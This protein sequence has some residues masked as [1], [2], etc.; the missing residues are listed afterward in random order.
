[1]SRFVFGRTG[2]VLE[3]QKKNY[4]VNE[5][6]SLKGLSIAELEGYMYDTAEEKKPPLI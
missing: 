3:C 6:P 1:M 2:T 4:R 5:P